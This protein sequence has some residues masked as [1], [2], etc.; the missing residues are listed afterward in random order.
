MKKSFIT[1][2]PGLPILAYTYMSELLFLRLVS[3]SIDLLLVPHS[4]FSFLHLVMNFLI[5]DHL[6]AN[7]PFP[8][9]II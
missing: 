9:I 1:S 7:H 6:Q 3:S 4:W 2:G 8:L 5:I